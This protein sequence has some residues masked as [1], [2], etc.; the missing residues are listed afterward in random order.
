[1]VCLYTTAAI[2]SGHSRLQS[3]ASERNRSYID[4]TPFFHAWEL[5]GIYPKIFEQEGVGPKAKELF[6][7]GRKLLDQ[8]VRDDCS[9]HAP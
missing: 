1:L 9:K 8:I 3:R 6:D 7:D 4:W 2:I 5:R